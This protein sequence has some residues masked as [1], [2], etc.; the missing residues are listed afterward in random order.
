MPGSQWIFCAVYGEF[1]V[2]SNLNLHVWEE[3]LLG[4][5]LKGELDYGVEVIHD[6]LQG[7][8]LA[9]SG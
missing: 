8:E 9:D 7:L 3:Y 4:G 2:C 5:V 6:V 1:A